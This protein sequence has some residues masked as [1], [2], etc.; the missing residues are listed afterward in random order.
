MDVATITVGE[1]E[2]TLYGLLAALGGQKLK[3]KQRK[4]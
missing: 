1:G 3:Q 2:V 4:Q